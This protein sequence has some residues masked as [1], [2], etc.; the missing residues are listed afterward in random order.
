MPYRAITAIS[1]AGFFLIAG[2]DPSQ[3]SRSGGT[4]VS[5]EESPKIG[6]YAPNFRLPRL[7]GG[8]I[9]MASQKG[10]VVFLN[11]WATW[12][13]PCRDE[14]PSMENLYKDF[15]SQ[16]LEILAISGDIEGEPVVRPF[17]M[18]LGLTYPIPL[19]PDL[20]IHDKYLIRSV[21]TTILV[22]RNGVITH[23][24]VGS[25]NWN[26]PESRDLMGKLLRSS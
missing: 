15:R 6:Y 10:K 11:F 1:L 18:E 16:G 24:I 20:R 7:G 8:E 4:A 23:R 12:C 22:D 5:D 13:A 17:A 14:M 21:P 2:C 19:D 25:R 26:T 9:S 3:K